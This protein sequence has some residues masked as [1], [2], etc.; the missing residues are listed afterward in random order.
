MKKITLKKAKANYKELQKCMLDEKR[1]HGTSTSCYRLYESGCKQWKE[2]VD[3]ME[4]RGAKEMY[5]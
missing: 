1:L 3:S 2:I 5:R 4:A